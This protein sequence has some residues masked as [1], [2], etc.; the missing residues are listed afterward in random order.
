MES[1]KVI[2]SCD[3]RR[4]RKVMNEMFIYMYMYNVFMLK[5]GG[6]DPIGRKK[7]NLT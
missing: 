5:D 2:E 6:R 3:L 1:A 7:V 4:N